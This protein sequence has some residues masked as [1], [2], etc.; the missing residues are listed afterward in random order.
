MPNG[1]ALE[2]AD[3]VE[4]VAAYSAPKKQIPAVATTP[5]WRVVGSF[6]LPR[7]VKARLDMIASVSASGLTCRARLLDLATNAPVS[8]ST[9]TTTSQTPARAL[10]GIVSLTGNRSYQIQVECTG[11]T[12]DDKFADFETATISD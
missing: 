6:F 5:G 8:G 12:G 7:T 1:H 3:T 10:S 4:V 2:P 11:A 9:A